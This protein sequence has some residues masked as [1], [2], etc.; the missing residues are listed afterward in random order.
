MTKTKILIVDDEE[1]LQLNLSQYSLILLDIMM[2][3]MNGIQMA[4]RDHPGGE[5]K[6]VGAGVFLHA[7]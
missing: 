4:R 5:P 3:E 7:W 6:T 1:T 2:G